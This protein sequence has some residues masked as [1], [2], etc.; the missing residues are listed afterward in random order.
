MA[1]ID[2]TNRGK[3]VYHLLNFFISHYE[4]GVYDSVTK[5]IE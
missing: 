3:P 2:R 4:S 5:L 1:L